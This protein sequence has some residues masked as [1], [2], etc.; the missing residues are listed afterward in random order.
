LSAAPA[1]SDG[2]VDR[3]A[4]SPRGSRLSPPLALLLLVEACAVACLVRPEAGFGLYAA[5]AGTAVFAAVGR[6]PLRLL[7]LRLGPLASFGVGTLLLVALI[8]SRHVGPTVALCGSSLVVPSDTLGFVG[9]VVLR[10]GLIAVIVTAGGSALEGRR[11]LRGL[12]GLPVP[13]SLTIMIYMVVRSLGLVRA[14]TLGLLRAR[15]S[16]G[17]RGGWRWWRSSVG[18][19][20]VLVARCAARAEAQAFALCARG[21]D[22]AMR[23]PFARPAR[24]WEWACAL[25]LGGVAA[26]AVRR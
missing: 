22:G 23:V 9:A 14:E 20:H 13:S 7:A 17:P 8:P 19:A 3:L 15:A 6:A 2:P 1:V 12:I 16:R 24:A 4:A 26:W 10:A 11:L 25:C 18:M 5:V 21:F